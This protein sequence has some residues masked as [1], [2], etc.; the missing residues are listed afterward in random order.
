M[1][2]NLHIKNIGIIDDINISLEDGFNVLTGETGAGKSLIIDSL[3]LLSGG[4]FSKEMMRNGEIY[5]LI[6]ACIYLPNNE[7][8]EDGNIIVSREI[9]ENGRNLCKIN[10]RMVTVSQLKKFMQ[11]IIDIH[12]QSD[13]QKLMQQANHINYI[14]KYYGEKLLKVKEE[15]AKLYKKY[16]E[17]NSELNKNYGDDKQ[18]QLKLDLL[19][20]QL[21]EINNSNLKIGE[22]EELLKSQKIF[23]NSEKIVTNLSKID[24]LLN[25]KILNS[26]DSV[27]NLFGKINIYDEKYNNFLDRVNN[28]Y[29]DMQD[30]SYTISDN[31]SN[32]D[33]DDSKFEEVQNRLDIIYNL[34]RKYGNTIEDILDYKT[35]LEAEI[36]EIENL[37]DYILSLKNDLKQVK[38]EMNKLS[39]QLHNMRAES[40]AILEKNITKE[41]KDLEMLNAEFKVEVKFISDEI[42]NKN[43]LDRVEF[44]ISTNTG[45]EFKPLVKIASGGELSR[46]MLAI[47][48]VFCEIDDTP[49]MIF[50]EIDTGISGV[51]ASSVAV[52]MR[53]MSKIHQIICVTHLATIAANADHNYFISKS[54]ENGKTFSNVKVLSEDETLTEIARI[55]TGSVSKIALEHAM[56]LR[57]SLVR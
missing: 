14:D 5:S 44:L 53:K 34:K 28:A 45:E 26:L 4:R 6:E 47:K 2:T 43:G 29:Y 12:G 56:A 51:A 10:G 18:K 48:S 22:D 23:Q 41:L 55:S 30:L 21:N 11:N 35:K 9:Y 8:S 49:I 15:Y 13:N 37:D 54:V 42:Y 3:L 25:D 40:S 39:I 57:K 20:Y 31:F 50:D 33:Y 32:I 24:S 36:K 16:E 46:I 19:Y 27:M 7:F 52:K 17:I 1:I 38:L